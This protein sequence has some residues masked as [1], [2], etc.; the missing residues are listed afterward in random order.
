MKIREL[1]KQEKTQTQ[2]TKLL[3]TVVVCTALLLV[4]EVI[5]QIP[6]VSQAFSPET[7]N[8]SD[9]TIIWV[10]LWLLMFAQVT[11]I[12]V[13]AM[14]IYVFCNRT[15]L[16]APGPNITDLFSLETLF[17]IC[18]VVSACLA[19]SLVAYA[20][21]KF[22]GKKAVKW[23]AGDEEDYDKWSKTLN[24]TAGKYIYTA[25]V[26]LPIFPDDI[27]CIVAGAL[28]I[29][30]KFFLFANIF[31]KLVGA[32]CLLIFLRVPYISDFFQGASAEGGI[33]WALVV[34]ALLFI[35]CLIIALVRR[36]KEK[37]KQKNQK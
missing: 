8:N 4:V 1:L 26:F 23:I 7:L 11:I 32:F 30:F 17:F 34:Y 28:S 29:D 20:L 12:P 14:P 15:S 3:W 19:G 27:I 6:A 25:T 35:T 33:P 5:F 10:L 18:F 21:G 22:G 9:S 16:V 36:N 2:I 24:C 37:K 31:G 13:P